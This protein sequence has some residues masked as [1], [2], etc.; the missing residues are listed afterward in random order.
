[1]F[2][3]DCFFVCLEFQII[4]FVISPL[5]Q[6]SSSKFPSFYSPP[7]RHPNLPEEGPFRAIL[8]DF[9]RRDL[10]RRRI[11]FVNNGESGASLSHSMVYGNI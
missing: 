1:M 8:H 11:D 3:I 4:W 2:V 6:Y 9:L 7:P 5:R 10:R